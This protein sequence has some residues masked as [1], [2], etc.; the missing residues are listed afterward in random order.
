MR[1]IFVTH[2]SFIMC[3]KAAGS[4]NLISQVGKK[5]KKQK[6]EKHEDTEKI[7][8]ENKAYSTMELE[9]DF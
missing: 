2:D 1:S 4:I 5:K 9:E 3:L 8:E 7:M 6:K